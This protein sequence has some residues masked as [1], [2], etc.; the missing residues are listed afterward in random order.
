MATI[1]YL[2]QLA[3]SAPGRAYKRNV[4]A[5]LDLQPGQTTLDIGCGPGT[6]LA[7]LAAGVTPAGSVIGLD[8]DLVM[9]DQAR[10][11]LAA[12][13]NVEVRV[14]DAHAMPLDDGTVDRARVDRVLQHLTDPVRVMAEFG[15]VAR[16]GARIVMAE[17]DWDG[18][19]IDSPDLSRS[20]AF[21]QYVTTEVIRNPDIGRS[22][23]RLATRAGLTVRSVTAVTPVIS[24]FDT[25]DQLFGLRR[26]TARA[27]DA[28]YLDTSA[29]AWLDRLA[30]EPFLASCTIFIAVAEAP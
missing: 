14:G 6:D 25:A 3:A 9:V 28:G 23:A 26:T 20:R 18:L 19:L 11:R 29:P 21:T 22:L 1:D 27:V 15:R 13:P 7:D 24:D 16:P 30:S 12:Y 10:A 2:D 4:L 5:A 8:H 17:P